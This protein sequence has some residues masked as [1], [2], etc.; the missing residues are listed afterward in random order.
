MKKL[1]KW[2]C[3]IEVVLVAASFFAIIVM[4]FANAVLRVFNHPIVASDD[5]CT[6]LFAW[7]SFM[8]ADIALRANRLVGMDLMTTKLPPRAQKFLQ[9]IV[10]LVMAA[11]FVMFIIKGCQLAVMNWDRY[12]NT[13]PISYGVVTMSLPVCGVQIL[14]TIAI[15]V[16]VLIRH[17]R[18]D[19]FTIK[20][21]DPDNAGKEVSCV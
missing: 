3:T 8:G 15:K 13:L 11:T 18:D 10:Y 6:L 14:L 21:H 16:S 7:V 4:T 17:W 19:A 1:Y 20:M 12:F 2:Y 9:L 5:I